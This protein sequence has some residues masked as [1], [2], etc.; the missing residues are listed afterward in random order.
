MSNKN[1]IPPIILKWSKSLRKKNI[2]EI[3]SCTIH[4][5]I[6]DYEKYRT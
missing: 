3:L 1:L 6:L 4:L 2:D 5:K